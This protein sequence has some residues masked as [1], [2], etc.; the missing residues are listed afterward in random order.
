MV[1]YE[2]TEGEHMTFEVLSAHGEGRSIFL[3]HLPA[4]IGRSPDA[5]IQ[6]DDYWVSQ[7]HC[8]I[9]RDGSSLEIRDLGSQ[10][11]TFVNGARVLRAR[12][13]PGDQVTLGRTHIRACGHS[14]GR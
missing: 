9:D 12:L 14:A 6:I 10:T 4:I 3:D 13:Q 1:R 11:G 7:F 5:E 8:Q 2:T